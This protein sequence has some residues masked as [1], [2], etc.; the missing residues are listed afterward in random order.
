[1]S[2][3]SLQRILRVAYKLKENDGDLDTYEINTL[4]YLFD[5]CDSEQKEH[6]IKKFGDKLDF[7]SLFH[8]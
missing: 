4:K 3:V 8:D 2:F 1:M 7:L 6:L 5:Q